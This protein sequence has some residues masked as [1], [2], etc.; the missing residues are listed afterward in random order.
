MN[1]SNGLKSAVVV[2]CLLLVCASPFLTAQTEGVRSSGSFEGFFPTVVAPEQYM[3]IAFTNTADFEVKVEL[4]A[5]DPSGELISGADILN[6]ATLLVPPRG[7]T[8]ALVEDIFGVDI[9]PAGLA[10]ISFQSHS[11]AVGTLFLIGNQEST[12]LGGGTARQTPLKA[13]VLPSISREGELPF[14]T[15]HL[16]NPSVDSDLE[17]QLTLYDLS[18]KVI[19]SR[20]VALPPQ[21]TVV[22]DLATLLEVELAMFSGGYVEGSAGGEGVV[23]FETFGT[24]Q[25]LNLLSA[26]PTPLRKR[27]Y[28]IP[29]FAV[30]GGFDTELNLINTDSSQSATLLLSALDDEG[31]VR[32]SPV[33]IF[34]GPQEQSILSIS[35]LFG[36]PGDEQIVGSLRLDLQDNLL[37]SSLE[38]AS[39]NGSVRLRSS[40][41][42][43]SAS[44]PLFL[45]GD[46]DAFYAHI[47]QDL[48][49]L[50]GVAV[51]NPQQNPVE[52]TVEAFDQVGTQVGESS[53]TLAVGGRKAKLLL[54]LIPATAGQMGGYFRVRSGE[55]ILSFALFGDLAGESISTIP[56]Q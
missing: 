24:E 10:R 39:V 4:R 42:R 47:A 33:Q 38:V 43:L 23:A 17:V 8:W 21:G 2:F 46:T 25:S 14:T 55:E 35:S 45:A 31:N 30:G 53:F 50:T 11:A 36:L 6:P 32:L 44:L 26:Q 12:L 1:I 52:V 41:G 5:L 48:G 9:L 29:H 51:L 13:F 34:L 16:F 56:S 22:Q 28:L 37:D 20:T 18:G 27:S 19:V 49:F 15:V 3:G 40:D 7:Q 54:E